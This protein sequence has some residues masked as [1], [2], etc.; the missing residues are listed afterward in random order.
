MCFEKDT[1][2]ITPPQGKLG[3]DIFK[4]HTDNL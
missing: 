1:V 4:T 3:E 2:E